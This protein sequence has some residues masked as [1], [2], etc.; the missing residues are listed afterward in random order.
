MEFGNIHGGR[1]LASDSKE[2]GRDKGEN[3]KRQGI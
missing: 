3:I 1:K 2:R